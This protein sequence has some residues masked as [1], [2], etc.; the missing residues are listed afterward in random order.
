MT[1]AKWISTLIKHIG[2]CPKGIEFKLVEFKGKPFAH[3]R[4]TDDD[5]IGRGLELELQKTE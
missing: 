5:G 2:K 4:Y 1:K 3:F